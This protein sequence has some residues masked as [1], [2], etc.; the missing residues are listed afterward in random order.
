[1][2]TETAELLSP[3]EL[4]EVWQVLSPD[5]RVEGFRLLPPGAP[6]D[7]FLSLSAHEQAELLQ[8]L[9]PQERRTWIRL[10]PP[11][12][13][14]DLVQAVE[15]PELRSE[16][17]GLL[18]DH[19]RGEVQALLAYAEDDAGGLM[20]PRFARV[21]PYMSIDEAL[22]YLRKQ[23]RTRL[24][25]LS[26]AYALDAHQKLLGVVS[27]RELF[28][29][30]PLK[31]VHEVMRTDLVT[32]PEHMDQEAVSRL[33]SSS[34]LLALPVMDAEGRMKGIVTVDDIVDVVQEEA[35]EDIQKAG[36]MEALEAPY[37]ETSLL[38][39]MRKRAGW[40]ALLFFGGLLTTNAMSHF[41]DE[42]NKAVV[43]AL[44]A[45]LIISSGGNSGSQASTLIIRAMTLGEVRM[46]DWWRVMRR[47]L[48]SGLALGAILMALGF[49]RVGLGEAF[50]GAYGE[51][52]LPVA[53]TVA[54]SLLGVVIWGTLSGSML[55][56]LLRRLK[57]D[58]ASASAPAVATLVDVVGLLIYFSVA[59]VALKG[60]LL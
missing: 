30:S 33:F 49:L 44:F 16:L 9:Q 4:R 25:T 57:L 10:L 11:D 43:L 17:L 48:A 6:D 18:D 31:H 34:D 42:I 1:M 59:S 13:A 60:T 47:E 41:A 38:R 54:V 45:P 19:T 27:I 51:T 12:D 20:S 37:F 52:W 15:E 58:P 21:R 50:F 46:R 28:Q 40:L 5:E 3:P 24:E 26:Y 36:G 35:T 32:V 55:P 56:F 14:A 8:S 2:T 22:R 29:A 7:F 23:A 53:S 39:L